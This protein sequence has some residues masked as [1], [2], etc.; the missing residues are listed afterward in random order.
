MVPVVY[1]YNF[2]KCWP[3]LLICLNQQ[4]VPVFLN[5]FPDIALLINICSSYQHL[6]QVNLDQEK[7]SR[8]A[9]LALL[10][11]LS[12]DLL[13]G[14]FSAGTQRKEIRLNF[15]VGKMDEVGFK[16]QWIIQADLEGMT[17]LSSS[18][19]K[20]KDPLTLSI[21][22]FLKKNIYL[23]G[24]LPAPSLKVAKCQG[25]EEIQYHNRTLRHHQTAQKLYSE[26]I[27]LR[28]ISSGLYLEVTYQHRG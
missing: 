24:V 21:Y 13:Q 23:L 9:P 18:L 1:C 17:R 14:H 11:V 22:F 8:A 6:P 25:T 3:K 5:G 12:H 28:M 19:F 20:R 2:H 27:K 26:T 4:L 15:A 7:D 16:E 10:P